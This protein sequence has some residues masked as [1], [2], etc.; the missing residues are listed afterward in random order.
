MASLQASK[1]GIELIKQALKK[2]KWTQEDDTPL[3]L[4]GTHLD[5]KG[6]WG[7]G[8]PYPPGHKPSTWKRFI[9][10]LPVRD[11]TFKNFCWVLSLPWE[12]IVNVS[13]VVDWE[14]EQ[15]IS[16]FYG[17]KR[18]LDELKDKIIKQR[19]RLLSVLGV[20]GIGKTALV[21]EFAKEIQHNFKFV[22]EKSLKNSPPFIKFID[23]L[24]NRLS[25]NKLKELP[26]EIN[27]KISL[28]VSCLREWRCLIIIDNFEGIFDK[29]NPADSQYLDGYKLY[30]DF[31]EKIAKSS[32]NSCV[33]ITTQSEP[34]EIYN[35]QN[36][37]V[38]SLRLQGLNNADAKNI[39]DEENFE[40]STS[41][42]N[43]IVNYYGGHPLVLKIVS[44]GIREYFDGN[45][46]SFIE[47][48]RQGVYPFNNN[49]IKT[50]IQRQIERITLQG[51]V[52]VYWLAINRE[53]I[54]IE[55]LKNDLYNSDLS[56]PDT[57]DLLAKRI[58]IDTSDDLIGLHP[59]MQEYIIESIIS[60]VCNEIITGNIEL[61][62]THALVKAQS[63]D[64][65]RDTQRR[66]IIRPII[67]QLLSIL[68]NN[69]AI[70]ERLKQI[71]ID[72]QQNVRKL[73]SLWVGEETD[74]H[75]LKELENQAVKEVGYTSSNILN[76]FRYLKEDLSGLDLSNL[77]II[78][79]DLQGVNLKNT[80]F[81]N[82]YFRKCS[83][84]N[85]LGSILSVT[86]S[87]DGNLLATGDADGKIN[88][89]N[90][91]D[92]QWLSTI[93]EG[94][95]NW[96]MS[97]AFSPNGQILAS[98]SNNGT[99]KLWEIST[100][101]HL[102]TFN[103]NSWVLSVAFSPD[104]QILA[105]GSANSVI[106]LWDVETREIITTLE[107]HTDRIWSVSFSPDNTIIAS[108]SDDR[109]IR[110]WDVETKECK[111]ILLGHKGWVTSVAFSPNSRKLV[112][113]SIDKTVKIWDTSSGKCL[114]SFEGHKHW[115][116][117]VVF[118][119][120]GYTIAS[121]SEDRTVKIWEISTKN[122]NP[123][124]QP[125]LFTLGEHTSRIW[126]IGFHPINQT[127]AV[128][129][130]DRI[131]RIWETNTGNCIRKIQGYPQWVM[132]VDC[133]PDGEKIVSGHEDKTVKI[134]NKHTEEKMILRG[135]TGRIWSVSL[136]PN[137]EKIASASDDQT[138]RIWETS[139]GKCIKV[140]KGHSSIVL[141]VTFSP[142]GRLLASA[143][144]DR[145]I[146]IWK[147]ST[148]QKHV[149]PLQGHSNRIRSVAFSPD[150]Q[151]LAS[152]SEDGSIRLWKSDTGE[153]I[154]TLEDKN[155]EVFSISFSPDSKFIA[156]AGSAK[157][158]KVWK[159]ESAEKICEFE[160]L[161]T[162]RIRSVTFSAN[163]QILASGSE[164]KTIKIW[165]F[166]TGECIN[167]LEKHTN[168][169]RS[170]KF[171]SEDNCVVSC[172][173]DG[174]IR[175]WN[176]Q[177]YHC[178]ILGDDLPCK[179]MNITEAKGL[180]ESQRNSLNLLGAIPNIPQGS[181]EIDGIDDRLS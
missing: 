99:I 40:I 149:S 142:N 164:D 161:H 81:S 7:S 46:K 27:L 112:S 52:I 106:H 58:L 138:V 125:C 21:F 9:S 123:E 137:L 33:I 19:C 68:G 124:Y 91:S 17:R 66:L 6:S 132:S 162:R 63:K 23:S 134:W 150:G 147:L 42:I 72:I 98:G 60:E 92:A 105:S 64:Y 146:Q 121:S 120:G 165:Y 169:I 157:T 118:S 75:I 70:E 140:L 78:Q 15:N 143:G 107:K 3:V 14:D 176:H 166:N 44:A 96:I 128:G 180:T 86:F 84:T 156:S 22:I 153:H 151:F 177:N 53:P 73:T 83:F 43:E 115:V 1:K 71:I 155:D 2:R 158:I 18:E 119:P 178:H 51:K 74:S 56:I 160:E 29:K 101:R 77:S 111:N 13:T 167:T 55:T 39:I 108:G 122:A 170:V 16:Q 80:N 116:T 171:T 94:D 133:S 148:G 159:I 88:L 10:G 145:V 24:L 82:S 62:R 168:T 5:P 69:E 113:G 79:A 57:L 35:T 136:S 144:E 59:V 93:Q 25:C 8:G 37:K 126:D 174:T 154:E 129:C 32:H 179:N 28:V 139:T 26:G 54:T 135:H 85:I 110:I 11:R 49:N 97:I 175:V 131:L 12:S 89:W 130:D 48:L 61:L 45:V 163:G 109:T 30:G 117:S 41:E 76:F 103:T 102:T 173:Q 95:F 90:V 104:G 114:N 181:N 38:K 67:N 47:K 127:L 34:Q 100:G 172:S 31:L 50:F 20:G 36:K 152:G 141:T 4:I 87:P 65:I